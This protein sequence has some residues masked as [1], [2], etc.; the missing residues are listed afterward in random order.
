MIPLD[1]LK[2]IASAQGVS[3]TELEALSLALE[4]ESI[5]AIAT[6]LDIRP[7]AVRKRLG[8]VYKK[9]RITGAGPGK[10][11]KLQ[12]IL[13]SLYQKEQKQFNFDVL[14]EPAIGETAIAQSR[15]DWSEAPDVSIFYGRSEDLTQLSH[16]IV[17]EHCRVVA[18]LGMIGIGKTA[19]S[20]KL[21]QQLKDNFD[22]VIWR[23]LR[24]TAPARDFI[25]DLLQFLSHQRK[26]F[27]PESLDERISLLLEHFK[28]SRC[29]VILD[30]LETI[31][32]RGDFAGHY[33]EKYKGYGELLRRLGE[34]PHQSCL[35]LTSTEKPREIALEEGENL[36]VRSWQLAGLKDDEAA[37]ILKSKRLKDEPQW[38]NLIKLYR[39]NPLALKIVSTTIQEIFCGSV[40]QFLKQ[41][42]SLVLRDMRDLIQEEF[43]RLSEL[44][45]E[46]ANWLAIVGYPIFLTDLKTNI[47]IPISEL[48]LFEALESLGRRSLIEK[49]SSGFTLPPVVMEF[50]KNQLVEKMTAE[51]IELITNEK[52]EK[53]AIIKYYCLGIELEKKK[54]PE[55]GNQTT[56]EKII[57]NLRQVVRNQSS[58]QE[59]LNQI[60]IKLQENSNLE[61]G[62][63]IDNVQNLIAKIKF[64]L[65]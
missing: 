50:L 5:L 29:L 48:K 32:R 40:L 52:P 46:I 62:Y 31:L 27:L 19:L 11:A 39:G 4:G 41:R 30:N 26:P 61:V 54:E 21:A 35:I 23:S 63:A 64:D 7:E 44:E 10:L 13:V 60:S 43:E 42:P 37:E 45:K 28:T 59:Q 12:Q 14:T 51:I 58:L 16:W 1:F 15:Q 47:W 55:S 38:G 57:E 49:T 2:A 20:V 3:D 22:C 25:A 53:L 18:L 56:I 17:E 33:E 36:P 24:H 9:F 34:E 8:E 6:K 65:T